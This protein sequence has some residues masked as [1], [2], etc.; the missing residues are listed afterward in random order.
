MQAIQLNIWDWQGEAPAP[1]RTLEPVVCPRDTNN[2]T[3]Y[4]D[5]CR[6]CPLRELCDDD[7]CAMHLYDIMNDSDHEMAFEDWLTLPLTPF[8]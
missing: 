5:P 1:T 7:E 3:L 8:D 2:S 4:L 6:G